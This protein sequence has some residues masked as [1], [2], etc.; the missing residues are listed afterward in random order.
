MAKFINVEFR[1]DLD[2]SRGVN[3]DDAREADLCVTFSIG[4]EHYEL[5]L[6]EHNYQELRETF[7][8]WI[9]AG[10]KTDLP[11]PSQSCKGEDPAIKAAEEAAKRDRRDKIRAWAAQD[12][13]WKNKF[14]GKGR[15]PAALERDYD[16][17]HSP[18]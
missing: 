6:A 9:A 16:N 2:L 7:A 14:N 18:V 1:D 15:I 10:R 12:S 11:H 8:S 3:R 17:E 4:V 5:D 13:V